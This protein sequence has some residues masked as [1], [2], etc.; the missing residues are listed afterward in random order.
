MTA[1]ASR[2]PPRGIRVSVIMSF[3]NA[4]RFLAEAISSVRQQTLRDWEL[5]LVNDGST[6]ASVGIAR[7]AVSEDPERIR[8]LEHP[9]GGNRGLLS[10]RKLGITA[11]RGKWITFL[12][13]D[14]RFD[15]DRLES[16][17]E[18]LEADPTLVGVQGLTRYWYSWERP[19][20]R[21]TVDMSP[22]GDGDGVV[23][24]PG[25]LVLL[26]HSHGRTAPGICSVTLRTDVARLLLEQE[27]APELMYE[28]QVLL[29]IAYVAGRVRLLNEP[30]AWYRQH[31]SSMSSRLGGDG[32]EA[33]LHWLTA[34]LEQQ[35]ADPS[36]LERVRK[37]QLRLRR[38]RRV[39]HMT[40]KVLT[41]IAT[42]ILPSLS[43]IRM[44]RDQ[45]GNRAV[46]R[47]YLES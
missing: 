14:D 46:L 19:D 28:D 9:G 20:R 10:S 44:K 40:G 38:T 33:W 27:G 23:R 26:L 8:L 21:D 39:V 5:V 16:H 17:V 32:R 2:H 6:D 31:A 30:H 47:P 18:L 11:A 3:L 45:A 35:Q 34:H 24:A 1:S 42:G 29:S 22:V 12:D 41:R 25:L 37:E 13:A 4:E 15:A 43:R 7:R 36:L